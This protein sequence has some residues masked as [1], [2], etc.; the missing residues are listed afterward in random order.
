VTSFLRFFFKLL[1]RPVYNQMEYLSS[2]ISQ[3]ELA[4]DSSSSST[5]FRVSQLQHPG[6]TPGSASSNRLFASSLC[7]IED[8]IHPDYHALCINELKETP[9]LHRKQW[10]WALILH[11]LADRG[12][13]T[14]QSRGLGF[15][16]GTEPL[17]S[18]FAHHG[19]TILGTDAPANVIDPLWI[20]N[21]E[22]SDN[23]NGMYHDNL[24]ERD[25][26]DARCAFSELDMNKHGTIPEG[27]DFHWSSC[28]IEHL[29]NIAKAQQFI[30]QSAHRLAP[31]GI[32]VHTTE[33]NLSSAI[34]TYDGA[35]TCIFRSTDLIALREALISEGFRVDPLVFD[36]G[37]HPYN[38][39]VDIPPYKSLVHTRLMLGGYASTSVSL[40]FTKP[41]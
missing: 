1:L 25:I 30:L 13:L 7:R 33:F 41:G 35:D 15:G 12:K 5:I 14:P 23:I 10:E 20:L 24:I 18:V 11:V 21:G 8:F 40:I 28:V 17:S 26:F 3:L 16:V 4:A 2:R 31:G 37:T 38:Y 36:P 39:H 27:Y 29:G 22:H 32:G 6:L 9:R 19:C 34:D